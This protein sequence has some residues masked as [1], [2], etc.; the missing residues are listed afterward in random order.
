MFKFTWFRFAQVISSYNY[1]DTK[2]LEMEMSL[3]VVSLSFFFLLFCSGK[4]RRRFRHENRW[5]RK[6]GEVEDW[7]CRFTAL[8]HELGSSVRL[9]FVLRSDAEELRTVSRNRANH[10]DRYWV[11]GVLQH[12]HDSI[13]AMPERSFAVLEVPSSVG[14]L[15][16]LSRSLQCREMFISRAGDKNQW[17]CFTQIDSNASFRRSTRHCLRHSTSK[18]VPRQRY[19]SGFSAPKPAGQIR[20]RKMNRASH[21]INHIRIRKSFWQ[22]LW[23][24]RRRWRAWVRRRIW[25]GSMRKAELQRRSWCRSRRAT[26]HGERF[27]V[28]LFRHLT[29]PS[30]VVDY[31]DVWYFQVIIVIWQFINFSCWKLE[32]FRFNYQIP[33]IC[34]L[35]NCEL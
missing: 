15:S 10:F 31:L 26:F 32:N 9:K 7:P 5:C 18:M 12:H 28:K 24:K 4:R 8:E 16:D 6:Y 25:A 23:A 2:T 20:S 14:A 1:A 30:W 3:K 19:V 13:H 11:P 35:H 21:R 34:V 33:I 27:I 29:F 22:K 17:N